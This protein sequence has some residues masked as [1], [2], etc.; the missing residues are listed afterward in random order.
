MSIQIVS[1]NKTG[2]S[3][4]KHIFKVI[5]YYNGDWPLFVQKAELPV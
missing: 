2:W 5:D 3:H 4:E 1:S